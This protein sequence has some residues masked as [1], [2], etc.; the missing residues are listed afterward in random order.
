MRVPRKAHALPTSFSVGE[1][2]GNVSGNGTQPSLQ[3]LL[4]SSKLGVVSQSFLGKQWYHLNHLSVQNIGL[5]SVLG[6]QWMDSIVGL[7]RNVCMFTLAYF[8]SAQQ[9]DARE[10]H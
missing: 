1:R 3:E 2:G 7:F 5:S 6:T 10:K 8:F 4:G 9:L